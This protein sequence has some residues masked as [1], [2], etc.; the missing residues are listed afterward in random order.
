MLAFK[1]ML[2]RKALQFIPTICKVYSQWKQH[3]KVKGEKI[4]PV[5]DEK[6]LTEVENN[7]ENEE[8]D[9][10]DEDKDEIVKR[11]V[12]YTEISQCKAIGNNNINDGKTS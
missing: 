9:A 11:L 12:K 4:V 1:I 10:D 3:V 8:P 6:G 2:L 5:K 7:G